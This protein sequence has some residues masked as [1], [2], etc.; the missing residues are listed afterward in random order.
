[1]GPRFTHS[2]ANV[3]VFPPGQ[4]LGEQVRGPMEQAFGADFADVRV[5]E[6]AR[7]AQVGAWAYTL[8]DDIHFQPGM[9]QPHTTEGQALLGHE[10]THVI[11]QRQA[12]FNTSTALNR[13]AGLETEAD[14]AGTRAARGE[15]VTVTGSASGVQAKGPDDLKSLYTDVIEV[16]D[17]LEDGQSES[18]D[19]EDSLEVAEAQDNEELKGQYVTELDLERQSE[20]EEPENAEPEVPVNTA[21]ARRFD[22]FFAE[23]NARMN[24]RREEES[25]EETKEGYESDVI[26]VHHN[27]STSLAS[28][29][30]IVNEGK[31]EVSDSEGEGSSEAFGDF[32]AQRRKR[33]A[34]AAST[35]NDQTAAKSP[36][37]DVVEAVEVNSSSPGRERSNSDTVY[38]D[39]IPSAPAV[40]SEQPKLSKKAKKIH[41]AVAKGVKKLEG[42]DAAL[43][44]KENGEYTNTKKNA[45]GDTQKTDFRGNTYF[46][47]GERDSFQIMFKEGSGVKERTKYLSEEERAKFEVSVDNQGLLHQQA[48]A[49]S[50]SD[51]MDTTNAAAPTFAG[52][53]SGRFIVV[54]DQSGHIYAMDSQREMFQPEAI[55]KQEDLET[56]KKALVAKLRQQ[57]QE[58]Q[59][60]SSVAQPKL[61]RIHHSTAIAGEDASAAGEIEIKNG[62]IVAISDVSGHYKP[63]PEMMFQ[64]T[65]ELTSRNPD[66][67]RDTSLD[68]DGNPV[69]KPA[70][71]ELI[72]KHLDHGVKKETALAKGITLTS[73]QF[74][75][76]YGNETGIRLKKDLN[77]E[78]E[79]KHVADAYDEQKMAD[80]E[81]R[82]EERRKAQRDLS[83]EEFSQMSDQLQGMGASLEEAVEEPVTNS[84]NQASSPD[85]SGY[86]PVPPNLGALDP[87]NLG[88]TGYDSVPISEER[89]R[90]YGL[91]IPVSDPGKGYGVPMPVSDEA[92]KSGYGVPI[93]V[94]DDKPST[95]GYGVPLPTSSNGGYVGEEFSAPSSNLQ[96]GRARGY[97]ISFPVPN[98]PAPIAQQ[99]AQ[100]RGNIITRA[101]NWIKRKLGF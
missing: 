24:G 58:R 45:F 37:S 75:Q 5:H 32:F 28:S 56:V 39:F 100:S 35:A 66:A 54:M 1:M 67:L 14:T 74:A 18:E 48:Y 16:D 20:D 90:G 81:A 80:I 83:A 97:G 41:K 89:K 82:L 9:Y 68:A 101:I 33:M 95:G 70:Q 94:G 30:E 57:A 88:T 31:Q 62:R 22:Q 59:T 42:S 63:T 52:S 47:P 71:I 91:E 17:E 96:Q 76:T 38:S 8:N 93:P 19:E 26:P 12:G 51:V 53:S 86:D 55:L 25:V 6:S 44:G 61:E 7:P 2:F 87:A 84:S 3:S 49:N 79:S 4:P 15:A 43:P 65:Q 34:Q 11:Q 69:N 21:F 92:P 40:S 27:A 23:R 29:A 98:Q 64:L 13:D 99:P 77:Q 10:L 60:D 72:G 36:Y 46:E 73:D 78:I 50:G 85:A